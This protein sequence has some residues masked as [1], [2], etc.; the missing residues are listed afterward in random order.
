M[1]QLNKPAMNLDQPTFITESLGKQNEWDTG[2]VVFTSVIL[3]SGEELVTNSK[4]T[5]DVEA[6]PVD[7][8]TDHET[9][10]AVVEMR[11][12]LEEDQVRVQ[13]NTPPWFS[14]VTLTESEFRDAWGDWLQA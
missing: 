12:G 2:R 10:T 13:N 7:I 14:A 6:A 4:V 11:T 3:P 8:D 5:V 9:I 1:Q